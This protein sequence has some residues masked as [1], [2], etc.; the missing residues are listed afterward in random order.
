[1]SIGSR[2]KAVKGAGDRFGKAAISAHNR[3]VVGPHPGGYGQFF[4]GIGKNVLISSAQACGNRQNNDRS[5]YPSDEDTQTITTET[6]MA[7]E[8]GSTA[9]PALKRPPVACLQVFALQGKPGLRRLGE[10]RH[11][12]FNIVA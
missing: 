1:M 12:V 5:L 8:S 11:G 6:P 2:W 4:P 3:P 10:S 7:F 9:Q